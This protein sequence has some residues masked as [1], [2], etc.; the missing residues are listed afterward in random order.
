MVDFNVVVLCLGADQMQ[1]LPPVQSPVYTTH[2]RVR[3]PEYC[4]YLEL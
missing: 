1:L 2:C 3:I 4:A